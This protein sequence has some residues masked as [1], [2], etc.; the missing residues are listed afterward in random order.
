MH[1]ARTTLCHISGNYV[2]TTTYD[3]NVG[4][5]LT[6]FNCNDIRLIN[7]GMTCKL[8][9][10]AHPAHQ[11][12]TIQAHNCGN[13]LHTH[14]ARS[15]SPMQNVLPLPRAKQGRPRRCIP[16][17]PSYPEVGV[18]ISFF[19]ICMYN[20]AESHKYLTRFWRAPCQAIHGEK[21]S[22]ELISEP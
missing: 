6:R 7:R 2:K 14:I 16:Y 17:D 4:H 18:L 13:S 12:H 22:R 3:V 9:H 1:Q 21:V 15:L 20:M 8:T 19:C 11:A 5:L 10:P